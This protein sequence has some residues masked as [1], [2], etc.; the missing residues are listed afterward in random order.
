MNEQMCVPPAKGRSGTPAVATKSR[1]T[2]KIYIISFRKF[3]KPLFFYP[4]NRSMGKFKNS[5]QQTKDNNTKNFMKKNL[6]S[7]LVFIFTI[8]MFFF[9]LMGGDRCEQIDFFYC[10]HIFLQLLQKFSKIEK[11]W[12]WWE[13]LVKD[14]FLQCE[15]RALSP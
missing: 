11:T 13:K 3:L 12:F 5:V 14:F 1:Y 2:K 8:F 10:Y 7:F 15:F 9:Y 4:S 6:L